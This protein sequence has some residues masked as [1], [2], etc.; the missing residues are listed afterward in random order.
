MSIRRGYS[1]KVKTY[2]LVMGKENKQLKHFLEL[3]LQ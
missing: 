2:C 3:S 1:F